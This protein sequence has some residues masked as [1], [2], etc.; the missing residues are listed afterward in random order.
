M[1]SKAIWAFGAV[2]IAGRIWSSCR[3]IFFFATR[4]R[5]A[6][7]RIWAMVCSY[8]ALMRGLSAFLWKSPALDLLSLVLVTLFK[9]LPVV[10]R[11]C[12]TTHSKQRSYNYQH[13][14]LE[15]SLNV[16]PFSPFRLPLSISDVKNSSSS[17]WYCLFCCLSTQQ[18]EMCFSKA[19]C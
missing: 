17:I 1:Y 18:K 9:T 10:Y 6:P 8:K 13:L 7:H 4:G 11:P 12:I 5:G 15:C 2:W 19:Q 3:W 14:S 16:V